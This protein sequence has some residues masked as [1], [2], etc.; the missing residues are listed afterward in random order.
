MVFIKHNIRWTLLWNSKQEEILNYR[1]SDQRLHQK[2][3]TCVV[4]YWSIHHQQGLY[5]WNLVH[6]VSLM[7]SV[8]LIQNFQTG[9]IY[10]HFLISHHKVMNLN[11]CHIHFDII[12]SVKS[13]INKFVGF[14]Y[15]APLKIIVLE[16]V[17]R[18]EG[19]LK[20]RVLYSFC[21]LTLLALYMYLWYQGVIYI[22][23]VV[24]RYVL[25]LEE[26]SYKSR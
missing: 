25:L 17:I 18:T 26:N 13:V 3:L 5:L 24:G 19:I 2:Q 10:P 1:C 9:V 11:K 20:S 6:T 21:I 8:I 7:N 14:H 4:D 12:I 23:L 16:L 15:F 22:I